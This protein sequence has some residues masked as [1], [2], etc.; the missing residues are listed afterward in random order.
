[1]ETV[2]EYQ[3]GTMVTKFLYEICIQIHHFY[4]INELYS[5]LRVNPMHHI[6]F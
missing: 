5:Q 3:T 2:I 4:S 6:D 1:M